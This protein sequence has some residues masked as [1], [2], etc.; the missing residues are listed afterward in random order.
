M[1]RTINTTLVLILKNG[2]VLLAQKKRGFAMGTFNGIGGKQDPGETIE[3]AMI[4]ETQEEIGVTPTA[5]KQVGLIRFDTWYKGERVDLNLNIY[6][7]THFAGEIIETEEMIPEWFDMD[8]I[9]FDAQRRFLETTLRQVR[10]HRD[11]D[12]LAH[13]TFLMKSP[14]N[15]VRAPLSFDAHR[16]VLDEILKTLAQKGKGLEMNTSGVDRSVG[17]LPTIDF[18]RR[19]KE[20]GGEIVT[21]GSDAH[22]A[23]RVGQYCGDAAKMLGDIFGYVCTFQDRTP[24]FHKM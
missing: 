16:E 17:F 11:F 1:K 20:L 3:Q 23:D 9:P 4:R 10:E 5:F 19:F 2:K 14:Y 18:F 15:P 13:L 12:V 8:K 7:C 6:T 22:R 21:V 24:I